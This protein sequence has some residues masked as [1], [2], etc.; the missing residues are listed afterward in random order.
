MPKKIYKDIAPYYDR[1]ME[2]V[3]YK[4]W[5]EYIKNIWILN[6]VKPKTIL[7]LGC[8]TGTPT[9]YLLKEGYEVIGVDGSI[10]MLKVAREKLSSFNPLLFLGR[11]ESFS[12]RSKVDLVIS[13][14]DSLNNLLKVN[15]LLQA[16]TCVGNS[17]RDGGLFVFDMNTVF[18]LSL[19]NSSSTFTKENRGVY[20]VWKSSFDRK[21][22]CTT[23][24]ITL[25]VSEDGHY[26]RIEETHIE[27]GY[28]LYTLK[29]LLRKS[30]FTKISFYEHLTFRRPTART[31][32]VM[33]AAKRG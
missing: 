14:F 3:N 16:F 10:E 23:L 33:I 8:G 15:D 20:S 22:A 5:I 24:L 2:E 9:L 25:F 31:K 4:G 13:L 21:K 12:L 28:Y 18:G 7:D 11:F 17:L 32:R 6:H 29:R 30:G 1:L 19:M 27:K 26:R